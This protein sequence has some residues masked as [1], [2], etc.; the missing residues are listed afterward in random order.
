MSMLFIASNPSTAS[1]SPISPISLVTL[2]ACS[3]ISRDSLPSPYFL[4]RASI[5]VRS[6]TPN[7]NCVKTVLVMYFASI[8]VAFEYKPS[9]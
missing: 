3:M 5:I 1:L 7:L 9:K 2:Y 8:G 4:D 6:L